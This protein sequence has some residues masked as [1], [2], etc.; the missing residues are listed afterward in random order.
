MITISLPIPHRRISPNGRGHWKTKSKHTKLA[1]QRAKLRTLEALGQH[2]HARGLPV[3][4]FAGYSLRHYFPTAAERDDDNAD[5]ACK[6][7]RDGIADALGVDD[8]GLKKLRLS[9]MGKDA[10]EPRVE[11]TL[12]ETTDI[13]CLTHP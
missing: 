3:P 6:A 11:I 1:R 10:N 12:Y 4:V 2:F 13:P 8:R 7:Y 5:G 9:E